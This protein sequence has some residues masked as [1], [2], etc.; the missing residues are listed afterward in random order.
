M[1]PYGTG[2][3][4]FLPLPLEQ[5][6][7]DGCFDAQV[8]GR[9]RGLTGGS[10][11]RA[12]ATVRPGVIQENP[13]P[14]SRERCQLLLHLALRKLSLSP[15]LPPAFF[16]ICSFASTS[17]SSILT[18][19]DEHSA[20]HVRLIHARHL[21]PE[22][23]ELHLPLNVKLPRQL[24]T[25]AAKLAETSGDETPATYPVILG[26]LFLTPAGAHY[27]V[28]EK[29]QTSAFACMWIYR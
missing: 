12:R 27:K 25:T 22:K 29:A 26:S 13:Y 16:I 11:A 3:R 21:R 24:P 8:L 7:R 10:S 9:W 20:A 28:Q 2:G 18:F 5:R 4:P 17:A 15:P 23:L 6:C 19:S 1:K 14:L